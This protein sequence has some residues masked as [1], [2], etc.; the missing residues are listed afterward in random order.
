[1]SRV[2]KTGRDQITNSYANHKGWAHG[3]DDV[4]SPGQIDT[5]IGHTEGK[6]IKVVNY[7]NGTNQKMD[8]EG[9]GYGNYAMILHDGKIQSRYPVTLYGH[10]ANVNSNIKENVRVKQGQDLGLMGNT[11]NSFGAHLHFELRLYSEMPTS[12]NL[13][14]TS[15][16]IWVDPTPYL[17]ADLPFDSI[18]TTGYLDAAKY[19]N[20]KLV[21]HGWAYQG[22][23]SKNV[24]IKIYK[25]NTVLYGIK[26]IANKSRPDVKT[27]MKYSTDKVGYVVSGDIKLADGTYTIKAFVGNTQLTN[28]KTI[29]VKNELTSTSYPDYKKGSGQYYKVRLSFTNE[30][31]SKGS[32]YKWAG[33][34]DTWKTCKSQGYHIYDNNGKQLD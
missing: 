11:G 15:K 20:G 32:F 26:T 27:A 17:D 4:K 1:M 2:L 18:K 8:K 33:A 23:G 6:I 5:I 3:V 9:M 19:E 14:D 24:E 22:G 13:H 10:L 29:T 31:S 7:L 34:F 25:G 30:K 21:C 12:A 28:T 16:F